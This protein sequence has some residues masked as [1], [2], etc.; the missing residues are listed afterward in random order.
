MKPAHPCC[1]PCCISVV[2]R[3]HLRVSSAGLATPLRCMSP[4]QVR[5]KSAGPGAPPPT[6]AAAPPPPPP[7]APSDLP[8]GWEEAPDPTTGTA[9]GRQVVR[10]GVGLA[11]LGGAASSGP[12]VGRPGCSVAEW[13]G[14]W[15]RL[16][17]RR[18][19]RDGGQWRPAAGHEK[20]CS[21]RLLAT[22]ASP[23]TSTPAPS[24]RSGP[25]PP[26]SRG[27]GARPPETGEEA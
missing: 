6:P 21:V 1:D 25:S 22:Q 12:L 19:L 5:G 4:P 16:S 20:S 17:T 26:R 23:T 11:R 9:A 7:E 14:G 15:R 2:S 10:F 3:L 27:S 18:R 13:R 24:R 8:E